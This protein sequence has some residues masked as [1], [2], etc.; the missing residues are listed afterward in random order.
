[1]LKKRLSQGPNQVLGHTV[2][3]GQNINKAEYLQQRMPR[4]GGTVRAAR[5]KDLERLAPA[6]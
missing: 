5:S 4:D 6:E 3:K 2:A 1:M